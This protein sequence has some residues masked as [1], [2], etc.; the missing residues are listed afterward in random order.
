MSENATDVTRKR[1]RRFVDVGKRTAEK[2]VVVV[3]T[4]GAFDKCRVDFLLGQRIGTRRKR[5]INEVRLDLVDAGV[6]QKLLHVAR[7]LR[8]SSLLK[9]RVIRA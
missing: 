5:A 8:R 4:D 6:L 2:V 7:S 3:S 9:R 1:F